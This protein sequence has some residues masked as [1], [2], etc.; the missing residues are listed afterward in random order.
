[1]SVPP[2]HPTIAKD[3]HSGITCPVLDE[4]HQWFPPREGDSRSPC[5]ALNT[6][7]NHGYIARDGKNLGIWD[8][9]S[10]LKACYNLSMP[11]AMFL[12]IGGFILLRKFRNVDLH[13]VGEHGR[14]EHDASLV[15]QDTPKGHKY[16]PI[17]VDH[18]LVDSLLA[19]AQTSNKYGDK[20]ILMDA[21]CV[22]RARIRRE[23]QC[24]KLDVVHA[25]IARGEMGIF[26]GVFETQVGKDVGVPVEWTHE[27]IG[28]E[29][30]PKEWRPTH[31]QGLFDVVCRSKAIRTAM[32]RL[33]E[34]EKQ[35]L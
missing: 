14:I 32:A 13:E 28:Y 6:M 25:E 24:P 2:S 31:V 27:W 15:H 22:A 20:S 19:D 23:K 4:A 10:G 35:S 3:K 5:P 29:R 7:A 30:L 26:L 18:V 33:R 9:V 11:L 34:A 8:I 12:S 16:A 17:A 1:M 21:T